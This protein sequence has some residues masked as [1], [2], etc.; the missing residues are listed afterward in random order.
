MASD[1]LLELDGIKGESKDDFHRGTL[2][3]ESFSWGVSNSATGAGIGHKQFEFTKKVDKSSPLLFQSC[4][5]GKHIP[6]AVLYGRKSTAEPSAYYTVTLTDVLIS[7][8]LGDAEGGDI[9]SDSFS[10]NYAKIKFDY[11]YR[12]SLVTSGDITNQGGTP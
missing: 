1:Y 2:Q 12:S 7:S 5:T 8:Y 10:L 3:I 11:T 6:K 4:C 9:P